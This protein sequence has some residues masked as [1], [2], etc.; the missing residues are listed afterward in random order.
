MFENIEEMTNELSKTTA[1]TIENIVK[2]GM[3]EGLTITDIAERVKTSR[4]FSKSR[5]IMIAR[6]ESTKAANRAAVA[7]YNEANDLGIEVMKEW[8]SSQDGNVRDSHMDLDGTVIGVNEEFEADGAFGLGP[9]SFGVAS[10]DIN[11][12]CTLI[13]LVK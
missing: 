11:C 6:T 13:P 3:T 9:G 2:K 12:R 10:E 4:S 1:D 7:A 8:L 5:S